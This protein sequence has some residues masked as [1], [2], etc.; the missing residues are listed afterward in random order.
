MRSKF[1]FVEHNGTTLFYETAG[2]GSALAF[3]HAGICDSSMWDA[4]FYAFAEQY[5]VVR[6]DMRGFGRSE[7]ADATYSAHDDLR[8]VL[9]HLSIERATL[10]GCSMGGAASLN[11]ALMYP[12]RVAGLVLVGSGLNGWENPNTD[13][14]EWDQEAE[15]AFNAGDYIAASEYEVRM[16]VDGPRRKPE[17]VNPA[18]RDRVRDMNTVGIRHAA[19]QLGNSE[20][21][22][23]PAAQRLNEIR[24]P[25]LVI[26][27]D[28]DHRDMPLISNTLAE[29]IAG[30]KLVIMQGTAHVPNMEQPVEFNTIV[31]DWLNNSKMKA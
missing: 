13:A 31:R 17:Q 25:T 9:D 14:V 2:E 11:F 27:G 10:I 3:I 5:K 18:V 19:K 21:L 23:P 29:Q 28:E 8:A 15:D 24:V 30:A 22:D 16:W 20:K 6:H 4:Q 1:G 7:P 26:Y 12:D